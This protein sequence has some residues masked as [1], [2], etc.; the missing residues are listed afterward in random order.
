LPEAARL[1]DF[2]RELD[3]ERGRQEERH[4]AGS[5]GHEAQGRRQPASTH[6]DNADDRRRLRRAWNRD[7]ARNQAVRHRL[8]DAEAAV[9][10][11]EAELIVT[12]IEVARREFRLPDVAGAQGAELRSELVGVTFRE[13]PSRSTKSRH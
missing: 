7:D 1:A 3:V 4:I 11:R 6:G 13:S 10:G 8:R 2:R 12:Q 5:R 9:G